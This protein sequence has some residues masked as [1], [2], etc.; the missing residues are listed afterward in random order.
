MFK[1]FCLLSRVL[2]RITIDQSI[3]LSINPYYYLSIHITIY[4][5]ILPYLCIYLSIYL[6]I[7]R[8]I[9][10]SINQSTNLSTG[11]YIHTHM[12]IH[13]YIYIHTYKS[14]YLG[15]GI[16][17]RLIA[18]DIFAISNPLRFSRHP[19]VTQPRWL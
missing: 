19:I 6:S 14:S 9:Y 13:I 11:C 3:L 16:S 17:G 1:S 15:M 5:S 4:Q 12:Y 7:F 10:Q 2:I 18:T 8:S